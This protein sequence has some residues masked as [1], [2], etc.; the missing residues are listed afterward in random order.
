MQLFFNETGE[1]IESG[2]RNAE[3]TVEEM[4]NAGTT[5]VPGQG[6]VKANQLLQCR[7]HK[8]SLVD[9]QLFVKETGRLIEWGEKNAKEDGKEIETAS[10]MDGQEE[11]IYYS[12]A[13]DRIEIVRECYY[14]MFV[15][16]KAK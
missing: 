12:W 3:E 15:K 8:N 2:E 5:D 16:K 11:G 1:L 14:R 13:M 9:M 6:K 10:G 7:G 4:E